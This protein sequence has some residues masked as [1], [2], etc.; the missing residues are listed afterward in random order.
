MVDR[1]SPFYVPGVLHALGG[2]VQR[3][4]QFWLGLGRLESRLL[5]QQLA[6]TRVYQPIFISGLA[7]SGS[8]LL[9]EII[10]THPGMATQ[11]IKDYPL[12]YTPF[13]WRRASAGMKPSAP[14][15]RVHRDGILI[16]PDSP[17]SLEEM[18]WMPYFPRCHD[19]AVSNL[20]GAQDKNPAFEQFYRAHLAKLLL[21]EN[22]NRYVAKANYHIARFG[23]LLRLFPDARLLLP[24]RAPED[25]II[26]LLRQQQWF[27]A[28]QRSQPRALAFM[29]R[30][31]HF[32]FGLDR[33]PINLGDPVRSAAIVAAWRKGEEVRGWARYWALVH[34]YLAGLLD[35]DPVVRAAV[36]V[37]RFE[38]LCAEPAPRLQALLEHCQLPEARAL[39]A[40]FAPTIRRPAYYANP[41]SAEEQGIIRE[42]TVGAAARWGY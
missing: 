40:R 39:V 6:S 41:L 21:A 4:R 25:H 31:G 22:A 13:W 38:D 10:A 32:E 30:S 2:M 42:E 20:L 34:D 27:S 23:Y 18:I 19:P 28:G 35:T 1:N 37:V 36:H 5:G 16:T 9:H 3:H 15:E 33:Q 12:V 11:R 7:R 24:V 8:T 26:S 17:D 14:Q 29:Q